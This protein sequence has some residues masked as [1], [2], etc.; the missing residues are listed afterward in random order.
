MVCLPTINPAQIGEL[1]ILAGL[2]AVKLIVFDNI[3][4]GLSRG[5]NH[6][7]RS[8]DAAAR[9]IVK[10]IPMSHKTNS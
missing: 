9:L 5:A 8:A 3:S 4:Q 1:L 2:A 6:R 7:T 10:C